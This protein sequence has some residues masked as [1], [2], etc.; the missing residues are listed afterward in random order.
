MNVLQGVI[1]TAMRLATLIW[2]TGAVCCMPV[3]AA[4][5]QHKEQSA[6]EK[7][8]QPRSRNVSLQCIAPAPGLPVPMDLTQADGIRLNALDV[9]VSLKQH[10]AFLI[11]T[12]AL[13]IPKGVKGK[14][15]S[16]G[17]PFQYDPPDEQ[18]NAAKPEPIRN[19]PFT[20]AVQDISDVRGRF[21]M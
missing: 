4:D 3:L 11:Y 9:T 13:D 16:V 14:T 19:L 17:V 6:A 18:A 8:P 21:E 10:Q 20:K 12:C 15:I 7:A 1:L 5:P 2:L